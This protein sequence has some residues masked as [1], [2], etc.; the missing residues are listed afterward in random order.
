VHSSPSLWKTAQEQLA[1]DQIEMI[2]SWAKESI[3]TTDILARFLR[4]YEESKR[5]TIPAIPVELAL[6]EIL[7]N[8]TSR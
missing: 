6:I 3:I 4:A 2:E 8:N 1:A 7:G 5:S